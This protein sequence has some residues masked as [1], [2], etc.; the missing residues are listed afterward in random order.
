MGNVMIRPV[1]GVAHAVF[2]VPPAFATIDG[3]WL[4]EPAGAGL[5][6]GAEQHPEV[7]ESLGAELDEQISAEVLCA[8]G[9]RSPSKLFEKQLD[10]RLADVST[11]NP[12]WLPQ[13]PAPS[14][15]GRPS[16]YPEAACPDKD[17]GRPRVLRGS[18]VLAR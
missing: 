14:D 8:R 5:Y 10:G 6:L 12:V 3:P 9:E 18:C 4:V 17:H 1:V 11:L 7:D 16:H 2:A 15:A 13:C